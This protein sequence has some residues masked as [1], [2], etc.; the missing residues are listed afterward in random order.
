MAITIRYTR[1]NTK[2]TPTQLE[3]DTR[4]GESSVGKFGAEPTPWWWRLSLTCHACWCL[5]ATFVSLRGTSTTARTPTRLHIIL[6]TSLTL[7][8]LRWCN[9]YHLFTGCFQRM[10]YIHHRATNARTRLVT[11]ELIVL[12]C[13]ALLSRDHTAALAHASSRT[14]RRFTT[15]ATAARGSRAR[16][17]RRPSAAERARTCADCPPEHARTRPSQSELAQPP[18]RTE[19]ERS[20]LRAQTPSPSPSSP[21]RPR[22]KTRKVKNFLINFSTAKFFTFSPLRKTLAS[23]IVVPRSS[24]DVASTVLRFVSLRGLSRDRD[25]S[26]N[27]L[28]TVWHEGYSRYLFAL[29]SDREIRRR[30]AD[31]QVERRN[32]SVIG[33]AIAVALCSLP[34]NV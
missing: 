8:P 32:E 29:V 11:T 23:T 5:S 18:A 28:Y 19:P 22:P 9:H 2:T 7:Y 10:Q 33:C 4:F 31:R 24:L 12:N 3:T 17:R 15:T 1:K 13:S 6:G 16:R 34:R 30:P 20:S 27:A 25:K 26:R 21:P 14:E